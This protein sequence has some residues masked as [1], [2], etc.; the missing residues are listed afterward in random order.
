MNKLNDLEYSSRRNN[1]C[2]MSPPK[3]YKLPILETISSQTITI[4]AGLEQCCKV[5]CA[6]QVRHLKPNAK[7]GDTVIIKYLDCNDKAEILRAFRN[8]KAF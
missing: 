5:E 3:H 4:S 6:H 8:P 1:L 7:F 2:I